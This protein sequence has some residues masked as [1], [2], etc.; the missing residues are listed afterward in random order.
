[1]GNLCGNEVV[2]TMIVVWIVV[3]SMIAV[4]IGAV[5]VGG[6]LKRFFAEWFNR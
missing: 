3:G 2:I 4:A 5:L 6:A 1:V